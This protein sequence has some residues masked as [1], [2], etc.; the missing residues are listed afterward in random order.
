M[1]IPSAEASARKQ[2][3]LLQNKL[4]QAAT[5]ALKQKRIAE[6]AR[7]EARRAKQDVRRAN[8]A[9]EKAQREAAAAKRK[10]RNKSN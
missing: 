3:Q 1:T 6:Q 7:D 4:K 9:V 5:E 8:Q 10:A 2:L